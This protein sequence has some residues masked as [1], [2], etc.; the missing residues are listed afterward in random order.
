MKQVKGVQYSIIL[1]LL[2][3]F[4][5]IVYNGALYIQITNYV[6]SKGQMMLLL[7][8]L[9]N[10]SKSPDQ[11][12]WYSIIFFVGIIFIS[13][14][15][16]YSTE[17]K[18]PI[19]SKW[20]LFEIVLM[21]GVIWSQNLSYNGIILLVFA[22]IFY[23]SR[24]F[25]DSDSKRSWIIFIFLSFLM[26]LLTDYEILSLFIKVPSLSAYIQFYPSSIRGVVLFLENALTSL[27]V[28]IFIIS[29]LSY[30]LYVIKEHH[31]IEEELKM[32][33]RVNTELNHYIS[34]SEKIAEDRERKRIAREIH[35]TLGHALTGISAG[36]D[37][38]SVLIDV[39]PIRAKEQLKNVS[40]AV[41]EGIKD[42][43]GSLQ[44]LR[45]G[46]LQNNG[47]KDAL[48]LMISEYESLSK[49]SVDLKY[50]WGNIDLD[51]IQEDTIFRIIQ[52]SMTNSVRHGHASKMSIHFMSEDN[53]IIVL[54]DNG[55]GFDDLQIGYGL[56][57]MRERVSILGGS[58]HFKNRE[59]F[60]T[61]I[62]FPKI[63]GEV[64]DKGNDCR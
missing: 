53:N 2:I 61:K 21:I 40:N 33:S 12:F 15:K 50:E 20:N 25:Q 38:V 23:S 60:Y 17:K 62:V 16:M 36:I 8:E 6:I 4:L 44:R 14:Y 39:H 35:D 10:I 52:E 37:A 45:P 18:W 34:L 13:T 11:I 31:H 9:N 7:G 41:R 30:I 22:D 47:L 48:I 28:I 54:Q 1:L 43:R 29:L 57:Q 56:K 19:F 55:I 63:G 64:Y 26:L 3:N 32:L 42:V 51:V 59:G 49:L 24:E 46:A 27:N 5:T 58:I